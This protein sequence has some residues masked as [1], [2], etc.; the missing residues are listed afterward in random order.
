MT[1]AVVNVRFIAPGMEMYVYCIK[2]L[3][4]MHW[5]VCTA[6]FGNKIGKERVKDAMLWDTFKI[7]LVN[8]I[9][10]YQSIY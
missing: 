7:V 6:V 8:S 10:V 3:V 2:I 9:Y 5:N 1:T 4:V